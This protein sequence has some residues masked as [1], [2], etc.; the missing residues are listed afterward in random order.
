MYPG[1]T[2]RDFTVARR[3]WNIGRNRSKIDLPR[4]L[5]K[6]VCT[7]NSSILSY[8]IFY[9]VNS[10]RVVPERMG[11]LPEDDYINASFVCVCYKRTHIHCHIIIHIMLSLTCTNSS[12]STISLAKPRVW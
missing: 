5:Y 10:N 3:S 7:K 1:P 9:A 6:L 12:E 11:A 4:K 2:E 8:K